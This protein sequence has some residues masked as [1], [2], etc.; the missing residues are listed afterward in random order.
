VARTVGFDPTTNEVSRRPSDRAASAGPVPRRAARDIDHRATRRLG[1]RRPRGTEDRDALQN[2][3]HFIFGLP[4]SGSTLLAALPRQNPRI[5]AGMT[6][7]VGFLF[8]A[9]AAAMSQRNEGAVF[10]DE[11]QRIRLLRACF[12]AYY[13]DISPTQ[14]VFDTNRL[15][16]TKMRALATL[17]PRS[18]VICCV[19]NPA[20]VVDSIERLIRH[21]ASL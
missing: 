18:R 4:R 2:G 6:S 21:N 9:M 5:S 11:A 14:V 15:W 16:T 17:F 19:R 3:I 8:N 12:E 7:P 13:A 10:I 20:W 1:L